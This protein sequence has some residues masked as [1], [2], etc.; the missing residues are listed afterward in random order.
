MGALR[1]QHWDTEGGRQLIQMLPRKR[2]GQPQDL[3][4]LLLM[5]ASGQSGFVNGAVIAADDGFAV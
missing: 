1:H 2:L 3:D 4:V 5:L